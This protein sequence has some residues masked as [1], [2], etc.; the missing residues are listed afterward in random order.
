MPTAVGICLVR[1]THSIAS[2]NKDQFEDIFTTTANYNSDCNSYSNN[3]SIENATGNMLATKASAGTE[4]LSEVEPL[5]KLILSSPSTAAPTST[6]SSATLVST[7]TIS[8]TPLLDIENLVAQKQHQITYIEKRQTLQPLY[9]HRPLH[10]RQQGQQG[11]QEQEKKLD[12]HQEKHEGDGCYTKTQQKQEHSLG[13]DRSNCNFN[14]HISRDRERTTTNPSV[15]D[16]NTPTVPNTNLET[17]KTSINASAAAI[18]TITTT[19]NTDKK[20]DLVD[21]IWRLVFYVLARDCKDLGRSMQVNRRFYSLIANDAVL[22]K[23]TY[24]LTV[25]GSI[26][27]TQKP[28]PPSNLVRVEQN[29][30]GYNT[31]EGSMSGSLQGTSSEP[32]SSQSHNLGMNEDGPSSAILMNQ[33]EPRYPRRNEIEG[34]ATELR[35]ASLNVNP[36]LQLPSPLILPHHR[37]I[38][39]SIY[40]SNL[41]AHG[42]NNNQDNS[43]NDD[44]GSIRIQPIVD[45]S[46]DPQPSFISGTPPY[47][48]TSLTNGRITFCRTPTSTPS[49][50]CISS[51]QST[52]PTTISQVVSTSITPL[53]VIH[54]HIPTATSLHRDPAVYWKDQVVEWLEHEKLRCLRLGL[55]W[56]FN[57]ASSRAHGRRMKNYGYA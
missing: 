56:G 27:A 9:H 14:H 40:T 54:N 31:G 32:R 20:P 11:Q 45:H 49:P 10:Q 4:I 13:S 37:R 15:S 25:S 24:N 1:T 33:P 50:S 41:A 29:H 5:T 23:F 48:S 55:F 39:Q 36:G 38:A 47:L 7:L 51:S 16:K 3:N 57:A 17:S 30:L 52:I 19:S 6:S 34:N 8:S 43:E 44:I 26:F 28:L 53:S 42:G 46:I 21:D 12:R 2:R 22:W 18:T 35:R